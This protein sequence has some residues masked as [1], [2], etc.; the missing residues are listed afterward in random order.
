ML[1]LHLGS[2]ENTISLASDAAKHLNE[3]FVL[4]AHR[5]PN[6]ESKRDYPKDLVFTTVCCQAYQ[7]KIEMTKIASVTFLMSGGCYRSF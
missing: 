6:V 7:F 4:L 1:I 5:F 3:V 2:K